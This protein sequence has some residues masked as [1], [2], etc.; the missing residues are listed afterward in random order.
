MAASFLRCPGI[1]MCVPE[2]EKHD[3]GIYLNTSCWPTRLAALASQFHLHIVFVGWAQETWDLVTCQLR[4]TPNTGPHQPG[5]P[6]TAPISQGS[7]A[8]PLL[9]LLNLPSSVLS[10][11]TALCLPYMS[12]TQ[13]QYHRGQVLCPHPS[14]TSFPAALGE[15]MS[16]F[17]LWQA[18]P[19]VFR[20]KQ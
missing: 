15:L 19:A 18:C 6:V 12:P 16:S 8:P 10:R 11:V 20:P 2:H 3:N 14:F 17:T 7:V 4:D 13:G 1:L 5:Y 9:R